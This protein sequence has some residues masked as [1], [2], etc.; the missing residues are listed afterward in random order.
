ML[1]EGGGADNVVAD[2]LSHDFSAVDPLGDQVHSSKGGGGVG[3]GQD[4]ETKSPT[5][6]HCPG[7]KEP[8]QRQKN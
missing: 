7:H 8:P 2:M 5:R 1:P 6:G 3:T 4:Q